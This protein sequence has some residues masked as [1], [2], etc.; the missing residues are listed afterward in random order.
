MVRILVSLRVSNLHGLY[1]PWCYQ[2]GIMVFT[3]LHVGSVLYSLR[4]ASRLAVNNHQVSGFSDGS[5]TP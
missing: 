3:T 4:F 5:C 2:A 1:T